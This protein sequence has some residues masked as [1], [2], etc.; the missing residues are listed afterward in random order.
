MSVDVCLEETM[1]P[2]QAET[3]WNNLY[4]MLGEWTWHEKTLHEQVD[5]IVD[6]VGKVNDSK[7]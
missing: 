6:L 2:E 5:E 7:R 3:L 1:T 4:E